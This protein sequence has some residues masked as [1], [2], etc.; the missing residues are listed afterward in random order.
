[1]MQ[2]R[3]HTAAH[4]ESSFAA[5]DSPH[6]SMRYPL[7]EAYTA[8]MFLKAIRRVRAGKFVRATELL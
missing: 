7:S 2:E 5:P 4:V 6:S 3:T 1:M 8:D